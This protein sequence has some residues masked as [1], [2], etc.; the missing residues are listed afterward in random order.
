MKD[1]LD[2][3]FSVVEFLEHFKGCDVGCSSWSALLAWERSLVCM[4]FCHLLG[5]MLCLNT[6]GRTEQSLRFVSLY[7]TEWKPWGL[8]GHPLALWPLSLHT[9]WKEDQMH[10]MPSS[11][12]P[13]RNSTTLA[14]KGTPK[15][16]LTF[17]ALSPLTRGVT[18]GKNSQTAIKFPCERH[19]L[20]PAVPRVPFY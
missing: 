12:Q 18:L 5:C 9:M 7:S 19:L 3:K 10:P 4:D 16:G 1:R 20:F 6:A 17:L 11:G 2:E 13:P 14:S 15:A 8:G